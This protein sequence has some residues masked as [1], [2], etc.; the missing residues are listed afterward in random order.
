MPVA[1][2]SLPEIV[3]EGAVLDGFRDVLGA[4]GFRGGKVGDGAGE[5][6]V[7]HGGVQ[8][9]REVER[10]AKRCQ[11]LSNYWTDTTRER[12]NDGGGASGDPT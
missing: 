12:P 11:P 9:W 7:F 1:A 8:S 3:V 6:A 4:D 5:I 10:I 2:Q